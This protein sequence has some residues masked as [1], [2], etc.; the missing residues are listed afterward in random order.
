MTK[1]RQFYGGYFWHLTAPLSSNFV[2]F[3]ILL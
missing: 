1:V 2:Y 3:L